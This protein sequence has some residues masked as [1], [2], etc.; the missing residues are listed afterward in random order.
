MMQENSLASIDRL[1][2]ANL[3]TPLEKMANLS[4]HVKSAVI[5]MK[6]DDQTGHC[7][8]GNKERKL[9]FILADALKKKA[10]VIVTVGAVQSNHCR[11]TA[12]LSNR[13]GFK[14]ELILIRSER[15]KESEK[16]GNYLL[17]ELMGATIHLVKTDQVQHK[18][19]EVLNCL[20]QR[21]ERTYFIEGGGHNPL[22]AISYIYAI[23]ELKAQANGTGETINYLVLPTGTGTTQ[24]GLI[25][26]KAMFAWDIKIIGISVSRNKERCISEISAVIRKTEERFKL[27]D[28]DFDLD[29]EI[30]VYD[31]YVGER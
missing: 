7:F 31:E 14:T 21:G 5:Y 4:G 1:R 11:A 27:G 2:L 22:G 6:R 8:G 30:V 15:E 25:L 3:P 28:L 19:D 9:E 10:S 24:A 12:A 18:I 20:R 13:M 16:E 26:G 29:E 23:K 17:D